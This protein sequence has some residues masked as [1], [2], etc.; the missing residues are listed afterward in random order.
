MGVSEAKMIAVI[1]V[2]PQSVALTLDA[3]FIALQKAS[4]SAVSTVILNLTSLILGVF[5]IKSGFGVFGALSAV[6][7]AQIISCLVLGGF[8]ISQKR[9][10]LSNVTWKLLKSILSGSLP[11]AVLGILG[12]FYFKV[13]SLVLSYLKGSYETGIYGAGYKFLEAIIILP[14]T[15]SVTLFP[16]LSNLSARAYHDAYKLYI[17]ASMVMLALSVIGIFIFLVILPSFIKS[18]LPQYLGSSAVIKILSLSMPFFFVNAVQSTILLSKEKNLKLLIIIS[19]L[20][21]VFNVVLNILLIPRFSYIAASWITV[22]TEA[23]VTLIFF[24]IIRQDIKREQ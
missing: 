16:V 23:I 15:V 7:L 5:L 6:V 24:V 11:Y 9:L 18:Y 14:S 10:K 4:V 1:A 3:I 17:K 12:V 2:I 19:V 21:L 13:D 22:A 8:L 20:V